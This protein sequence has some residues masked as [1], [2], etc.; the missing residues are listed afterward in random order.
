M[1]NFNS[2]SNSHVDVVVHESLIV[3][4]WRATGFYGHLETIERYIS[5]Q[6]LD[7]LSKQ[8][9]IPWVVFDDFNEIL[10]SVEKLGGAEREAKYMEA[11]RECLNSCGLLI[12][13]LSSRNIHGV[14]DGLVEKGPSLD[15]TGLWRTKLGC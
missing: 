5:W 12:L 6:L 3:E 10:F 14:T 9:N 15:L 13:A 7:S 2:C 11:F 4:P 8:C 1:I